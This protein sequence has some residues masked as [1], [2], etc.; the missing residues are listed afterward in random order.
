MFDG[1]HIVFDV[2]LATCQKE[3]PAGFV[4]TVLATEVQGSEASSIFDVSI[5][6][7]LAKDPNALAEPFPRG[8]VEGGVT[9]HLVLDKQA[10][11]CSQKQYKLR[12]HEGL[13]A[14]EV[15]LEPRNSGLRVSC[16]CSVV[17]SP[18]PT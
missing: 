14:S 13:K 10:Q 8:L 11:A 18:R 15:F 12:A 9:V 2:W 1:S 5:C 7:G 6:L 4:V 3:N 17:G 16:S